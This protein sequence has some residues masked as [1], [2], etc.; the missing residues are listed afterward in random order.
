MMRGCRSPRRLHLHLLTRTSTWLKRWCAWQI[1]GRPPRRKL[2]ERPSQAAPFPSSPISTWGTLLFAQGKTNDAL[3]AYRTARQ[4]CA[5]E[6]LRT[7]RQDLDWLMTVY[8]TLPKAIH[9]QALAI[10]TAEGGRG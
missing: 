6:D 8:P 1:A 4:H 10:F 5:P 2:L 3:G 7:M 9:Q